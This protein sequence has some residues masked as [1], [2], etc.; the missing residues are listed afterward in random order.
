M[1]ARSEFDQDLLFSLGAFTTVCQIKRNDA[2]NRIIKILEKVG[3]IERNTT[4]TTIVSTEPRRS[5]DPME[6]V[7]I[8]QHAKD[9]IIKYIGAKYIF[10]STTIID[11]FHRSIM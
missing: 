4:S 2:E 6:M 7:D 5:L 3:N 8:E 9:Q 11:R 1:V 10:C